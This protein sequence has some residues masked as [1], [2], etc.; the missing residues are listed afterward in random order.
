MSAQDVESPHYQVSTKIPSVSMQ[1]RSSR[2]YVG[3]HSGLSVGVEALEFEIGR[4]EE[5]DELGVCCGS[6]ST[7]IDVGSNIVY[8]FA[9]FLYNNGSSS[10]SGIGCEYDTSIEFTSYNGGSCFFM[11]DAFD[12]IF[13]F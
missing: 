1:H 4:H 9:I 12:D 2:S 13:F 11:C 10:G 5:V 7:G 3:T 8:F 6:C